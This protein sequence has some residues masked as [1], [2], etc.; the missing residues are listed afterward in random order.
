VQG[1]GWLKVNGG[2]QL[3]A[4]MELA[5]AKL[6]H[7]ASGYYVNILTYAVTSSPE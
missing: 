2:D 4:D 6:I 7:K 1:I 3:T 5:S